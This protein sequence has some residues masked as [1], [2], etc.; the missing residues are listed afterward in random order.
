MKKEK[1]GFRV[2]PDR[3]TAVVS[4]IAF[5]LCIPAQILGYADRL[6]E[7]LIAL[8]LVFFPVLAAARMIAVILRIGRNALWFSS[9]AVFIGVLGFAFKLVIDPR[10]LSLLHHVSAA[11][12]YVAIV[13][14]WALTALYVIRTKWVLALLFL[15]PFFKHV[16]ADDLPVL[17][18]AA[19]PLSAS[20][21]LKECSMLSFMLA[22]S[23]CAASFEEIG[24]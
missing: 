16:L 3:P 22:L 15:I 23:F 9:F 14:L 4:M 10:G 21:W 12:L 1:Q 11:V 19:A 13:A 20:A 17:L 18:G 6:G 24:Q 5:A 2:L 7:P 8:T